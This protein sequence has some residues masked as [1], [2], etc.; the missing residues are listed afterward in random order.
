MDFETNLYER[1]IQRPTKPMVDPRHFYAFTASERQKFCV[2]K[3]INVIKYIN[4]NRQ[5]NVHISYVDYYGG[6]AA[7]SQVF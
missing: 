4:V 3:Y 6:P 7:G 2:N 5:I 1:P